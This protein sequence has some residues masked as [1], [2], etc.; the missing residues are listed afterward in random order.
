MPTIKLTDRGL[1]ALKPP[2][3]GRIDYWDKDTPSFGLRLSQSG[4]RSW[5]VMY[6]QGGR[7]RRLTLGVYPTLGLADARQ[8]A[9]DALRAVAHGGDPA[10]EKKE[11]RKAATFDASGLFPTFDALFLLRQ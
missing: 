6:R 11:G 8:A 3:E 2:A 5:V 4:R 10:G 9:K 7:Q 1:R